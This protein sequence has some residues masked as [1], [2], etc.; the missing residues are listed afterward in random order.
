MVRRQRAEPVERTAVDER[1]WL[2]AIRRA[3]RDREPQSVVVR[4][5]ERVADNSEPVELAADAVGGAGTL[6]GRQDAKRAIGERVAALLEPVECREMC[7]DV[8][9]EV[10]DDKAMIDTLP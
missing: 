6:R 9:D 5:I 8:I 7:A 4:M 2:A 10:L 3:G 1:M